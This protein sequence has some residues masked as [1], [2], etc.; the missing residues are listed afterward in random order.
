ME[1]QLQIVKIDLQE[2]TAILKDY[3][4]LLELVQQDTTERLNQSF[5]LQR[6]LIPTITIMV[7]DQLDIIALQELVNR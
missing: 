7:H 1:L 6:L 2:N 5:K 4:R 3:L